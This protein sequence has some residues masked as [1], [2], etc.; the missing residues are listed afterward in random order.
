MTK[1]TQK[2][3]TITASRGLQ[4]RLPNGYIVSIQFGVGNYCDHYEE[5]F[6]YG[7][8]EPI[9]IG[10]ECF[11]PCNLAL[12]SKGSNTAETAVLDP[13]GNFVP[14]PKKPGN[15]VQGYMEP[16]EVLE[17]LKWASGLHRQ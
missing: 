15:S 3:F 16:G 12:T 5:S 7:N 2:N 13:K 8:T 1:D 17:L 9:Y 11:M 6:G 10:D 4:M 14:Y